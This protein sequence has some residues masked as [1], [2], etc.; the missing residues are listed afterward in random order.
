M[1][2]QLKVKLHELNSFSQSLTDQLFELRQQLNDRTQGF[3]PASSISSDSSESVFITFDDHSRYSFNDSLFDSAASSISADNLGSMDNAASNDANQASNNATGNSDGSDVVEQVERTMENRL[4]ELSSRLERVRNQ[5]RGVLN[6][7]LVHDQNNLND[8]VRFPTAAEL[9]ALVNSNNNDNYNATTPDSALNQANNNINDY[10][11]HSF[12]RRQNR[13]N[14]N[15]DTEAFY[16]TDDENHSNNRYSYANNSQSSILTEENRPANAAGSDVSDLNWISDTDTNHTPDVRSP[17]PV[18]SPLY[19]RYTPFRNENHN[20]NS[21]YVSEHVILS[22]PPDSPSDTTGSFSS[23]PSTSSV[24]FSPLRA[25]DDD[26]V[27]DSLPATQASNNHSSPEHSDGGFISSDHALNS[28][29]SPSPKSPDSSKNDYS[30][31]PGTTSFTISSPAHSVSSLTSSISNRS[32]KSEA[33]HFISDDDYS[34]SVNRDSPNV[35]KS[36][37]N[38]GTSSSI[39]SIHSS[40]SDVDDVRNVKISEDNIKEETVGDT[41]HIDSSLDYEHGESHEEVENVDH[42]DETTPTDISQHENDHDESDD[43]E[44]DHHQDNV[45]VIQEDLVSRCEP[46]STQSPSALQQHHNVNQ[47][48]SSTGNN[49]ILI[50]T[51]TESTDSDNSD[52][53]KYLTKRVRRSGEKPTD[54]VLNINESTDAGSVVDSGFINGSNSSTDVTQT[55]NNC[56]K[57]SG[58]KRKHACN[59]ECEDTKKSRSSIDP[60]RNNNDQ[61]CQSYTQREAYTPSE[62][63]PNNLSYNRYGFRKRMY[64]NDHNTVDDCKKI[65]CSGGNAPHLSTQVN[66]HRSRTSPPRSRQSWREASQH[67]RR[68]RATVNSRW[69]GQSN[70]SNGQS[71][72]VKI[73]LSLINYSGHLGSEAAS[74]TI[75]AATVV[76]SANISPIPTA[77]SVKRESAMSNS[78]QNLSED[79]IRSSTPKQ[80]DTTKRSSHRQ[81]SSR[82]LRH[83]SL[84]TTRNTNNNSSPARGSINISNTSNRDF[85]NSWRDSSDSSSDN[86]WEPGTDCDEMD[87]SSTEGDDGFETESSYEVQIPKSTAALLEEYAS[88]DS[89]ESWTVGMK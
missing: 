77:S 9:D 50:S 13:E 21:Q 84:C 75:P 59:T 16:F 20:R 52:S 19:E 62:T 86:T 49:Q 11:N 61:K 31:D 41:S 57:S 67:L 10:P 65:K 72:N 17:N 29:I 39:S 8:E 64:D 4:F 14:S 60:S 22:Q 28:P 83:E 89:D 87:D 68:N 1:I 24:A 40:D 44:G 69:N 47:A 76:H 46:D 48:G 38:S 85:P 43:T 34:S 80:E 53:L 63:V 37:T 5:M 23:I 70:D 6:S 74:T 88:D 82:S 15:S 45:S 26:S 73:D 55:S 32:S 35:D 51:A 33:S 56:K 25:L 79:N 66:A 2:E 3:S 54:S 27:H 12:E 7:R 78:R 36:G 18:R 81:R 58:R 71:L 42:S 30:S